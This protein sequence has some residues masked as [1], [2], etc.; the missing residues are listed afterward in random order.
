MIPTL[1]A[2]HNNVLPEILW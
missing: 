2:D 1:Q